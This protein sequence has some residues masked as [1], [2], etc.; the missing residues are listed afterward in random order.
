MKSVISFSIYDGPFELKF[1]EASP[2]IVV[3]WPILDFCNPQFS[4]TTTPYF[5]FLSHLIHAKKRNIKQYKKWKKRASNTRRTIWQRGSGDHDEPR[6]DTTKLFFNLNNG[7]T[8]ISPQW[9][10]FS[11]YVGFISPVRGAFYMYRRVQWFWFIV[12]CASPWAPHPYF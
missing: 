3:V 6:R 2:M 10:H 4:S 11:R 9:N 7:M 8:W 1:K 5:F 12:E